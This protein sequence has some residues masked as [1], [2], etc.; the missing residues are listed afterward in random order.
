MTKK[1]LEIEYLYTKLGEK[2]KLL[3]TIACHPFLPNEILDFIR[4]S[5]KKEQ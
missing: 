2:E 5:A 4:D 1:E 3:D